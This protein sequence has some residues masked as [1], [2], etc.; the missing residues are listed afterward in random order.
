MAPN[1]LQLVALTAQGAK[2]SWTRTL[3]YWE[4]YR[5]RW[6]D[7]LT[8]AIE[9]QRFAADGTAKLTYVRIQLPAN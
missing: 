6:L 7:N 5:L 1:F 3:R 4:P 2:L 8:V 9:Q